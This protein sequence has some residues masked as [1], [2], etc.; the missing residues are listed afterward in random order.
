MGKRMRQSKAGDTLRGTYQRLTGDPNSLANLDQDLP[1]YAQYQV[2]IHSLPQ[3][4]LWCETWCSD[5]SKKR[6]KT[7]DLCNNPLTKEPKLDGARRIVPEWVEL[8]EEGQQVER[9]ALSGLGLKVPQKPASKKVVAADSASGVDKK[10][11]TT[12]KDKKK[13]LDKMKGNK[14]TAGSPADEAEDPDEL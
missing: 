12:K 14:Q 13:T 7:I 4:W 2:P 6:A 8:D 5:S 11:K 3:E 1:N 9:D 10:A